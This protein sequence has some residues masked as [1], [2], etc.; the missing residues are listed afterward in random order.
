MNRLELADRLTGEYGQPL[1]IP[2]WWRDAFAA[3]DD[4]AIREILLWRPRQSGKS[5]ALAA[6]AI[7]ELLLRPGAYVVMAA[8]SEK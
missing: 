7:T 6:L 8:A 2:L 1:E 5:Q 4:P 3:L